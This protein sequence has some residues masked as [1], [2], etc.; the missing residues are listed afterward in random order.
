MYD[1]WLSQNAHS[2]QT[3]EAA[4]TKRTPEEKKTVMPTDD[5]ESLVC[6][7]SF[8]DQKTSSLTQKK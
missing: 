2:R 8:L 6:M 7:L 1:M 5:A 4:L 3:D